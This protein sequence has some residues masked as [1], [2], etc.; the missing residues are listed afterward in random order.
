VK[1]AR[2][3]GVF[4][5]AALTGALWMGTASAQ[6]FDFIRQDV[7]V[8]LATPDTTT[9]TLDLEF[10]ATG[11][12]SRFSTANMAIPITSVLVNGAP[13]TSEPH[14]MYPEYLTDIVFPAAF[15]A[16][17]TIQVSVQL[18]GTPACGSGGACKRT[19]E[20]T[21]F[22]FP[23][24][25]LAW[26]H[27]DP[28]RVDP[29]IG[30]VEM[31][32]P[33]GHVAVAAHGELREMVSDGPGIERWAFDFQAPTEVFGG[34][35]VDGAT[36][37]TEAS[38]SGFPTSAIYDPENESADE[39]RRA[40][41]VASRV[42]PVLAEHYGALP[43]DETRIV[44]VPKNFAFGAMLTLGVVYVNEVVFTSDTYLVEQGMA[45]ET[46][47]FWWGNTA[48]AR[49]VDEGPFFGESMAEYAGWRAL[50]QLDGVDKRTAGM[51]MNAVWYM[52]T[53]PGDKDTD[54]IGADQ[55]SPVFVHV[56]YHKGPLVL[57]A[58]EAY[59]GADAFGAVLK[60]AVGQG[61]GELS[62][63]DLVAAVAAES[64]VDIGPLADQWLRNQG[65]PRIGISPRVV[66]GSVEL[67]FDVQGDF[68]L[69]VPI[70]LVD[71]AGARTRHVV[72]MAT[73]PSIAALPLPERGL[74]AVEID[75]EWTM[76]R[77]VLPALPED[78][79]LDGLV[80]GADLIEV[81]LRHG[82]DLPAKRRV[83]GSYDPLFDID[84]DRSTGDADLARIEGA[85]AAP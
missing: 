64:G 37:A 76:V 52:F 16:G 69:R 25:G 60:D 29:F 40:V 20:E 10:V 2:S 7:F 23:M 54:I 1:R 48:T 82:N 28:F 14:F 68:N 70:D 73:G 50:G 17:E 26:Y 27:V 49:L 12:V 44:T 24:P 39:V 21:I 80:D 84:A 81:A 15:G 34:Y 22:T 42:V 61:L 11:S 67:T 9:V 38:T 45:H 58:L 18:S 46:A 65:F 19:P 62:V 72:D 33:E 47:H 85:A 30:S 43:I 79:N 77:E 6:Q 59:V 32:V 83:D 31:R 75:P 41:D 35:A 55:S 13:G 56:V 51:R 4:A 57:R 78:V 63:D 53:R 5:S 3:L 66:D 71:F 36:S 8:D 74:A